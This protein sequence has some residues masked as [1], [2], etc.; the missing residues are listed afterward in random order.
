MQARKIFL[1]AVDL[2][3]SSD[4]V[5]DEALQTA[6]AFEGEIILAHVVH[7]LKS[8]FGVYVSDKPVGSLQES[9][10]REGQK[11]LAGLA[12]EFLEG[13]GVPHRTV[14]LRGTPW[15]EIVGCAVENHADLIVIGRHMADRPVHKIL[16]STAERILWNAPCS[17]LVVSPRKT[18]IES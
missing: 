11:K 5:I 8:L 12:R 4:K 14:I 18:R 1:I 3:S 2:T 17:V 16:G 10:H 15:T 9:I 6:C 13:S 7:E